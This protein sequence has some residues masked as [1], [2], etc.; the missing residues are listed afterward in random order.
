MAE[1]IEGVVHLV[2]MTTFYLGLEGSCS[3]AALFLST[4]VD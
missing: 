3:Y 4:H 2:M 1:T